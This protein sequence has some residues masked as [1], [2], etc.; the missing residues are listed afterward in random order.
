MRLG[1]QAR[2][3]SGIGYAKSSRASNCSYSLTAQRSVRRRKR[4]RQTRTESKYSRESTSAH[5]SRSHP[6]SR[7]SPTEPSARFVVCRLDRNCHP[8]ATSSANRTRRRLQRYLRPSS[9]GF[10]IGIQGKILGRVGLAWGS[11]WVWVRS[12]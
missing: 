3:S 9:S 4:F 2:G 8:L 5:S 11:R 7:P 1:S 10:G 6:R 12:G